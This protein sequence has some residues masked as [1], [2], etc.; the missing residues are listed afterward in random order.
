MSLQ[1]RQV[2]TFK[3]LSS[4]PARAKSRVDFPEPGGPKSKVILQRTTNQCV[5]ICSILQCDTRCF[6]RPLDHWNIPIRS[7]RGEAF[8]SAISFLI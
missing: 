1:S 6:L 8:E 5:K 7:N 2:L 3:L 4:F